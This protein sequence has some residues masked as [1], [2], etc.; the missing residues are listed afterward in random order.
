MPWWQITTVS[1]SGSSSVNRSASS[2][3]G[4]SFE[5]SIRASSNSHGSRT[6]S[7]TGPSP[8]SNLRF[9]PLAVMFSYAEFCIDLELVVDDDA[10]RRVHVEL[11]NYGEVRGVLHVL[12]EPAGVFEAGEERVGVSPRAP[13]EV[14]AH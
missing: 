5:P 1:A 8:A 7:S 3:M 9:S 6:S 11:L 12:L 4:T 2:D 13:R 14:L 10:A